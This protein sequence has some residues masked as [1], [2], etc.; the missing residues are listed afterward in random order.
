MTTQETD[1]STDEESDVW[2]IGGGDLPAF[3]ECHKCGWKSAT[4]YAGL[5]SDAAVYAQE[6]GEKHVCP[7]RRVS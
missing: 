2:V 5:L 6:E 1:E 7:K 4:I 3:A